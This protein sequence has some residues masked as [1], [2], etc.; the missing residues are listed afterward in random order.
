MAEPDAMPGK[1]GW[2]HHVTGA[3]LV[4]RG[5]SFLLPLRTVVCSSIPEMRR[6][7]CTSLAWHA[8]NR[9]SPPYLH[10][11][12]GNA[13]NESTHSN[14]GMPYDVSSYEYDMQ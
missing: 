7:E 6:I 8:I 12:A 10:G 3:A 4:E 11:H 14:E 5:R 1:A 13:Q 2:Q 9:M